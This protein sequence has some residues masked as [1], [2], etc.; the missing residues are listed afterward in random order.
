MSDTPSNAVLEAKLDALTAV[1]TSNQKV[2]H[3][4]HQMII[5]QTTKTNGRVTNLEKAKNMGLGALVIM[6]IFFV[7]VVIAV[8]LQKL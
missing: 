2:E 1:V 7:P 8:I 4:A 6:N 3:E 5:D